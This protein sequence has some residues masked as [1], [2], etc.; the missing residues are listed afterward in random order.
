[1]IPDRIAAVM[2]KDVRELANLFAGDGH[3][4]YLVGGSVRDA[5]LGRDGEDLDFTT[6]AR[7]DDIE[8]I[9][10]LWASSIYLA[11]KAFGTIGLVRND[12]TYEITTYRS[13]LYRDD[14]RKP[15]VTFSNDLVEDL[16]RRDFTVNA[17]AIRV[18]VESG[19]QPEMIDPNGGLGRPGVERAANTP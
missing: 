4:L 6:D 10:S 11:G 5:L 7:P 9:G 19:G 17:M 18:P 15:V 3:E 13:E 12:H 2:S 1:M 8:R 14:S 16:S